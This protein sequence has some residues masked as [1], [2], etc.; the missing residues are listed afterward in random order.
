M[1][2]VVYMKNRLPPRPDDPTVQREVNRYRALIQRQRLLSAL[3]WLDSELC[4]HC[5]RQLWERAAT[6]EPMPEKE[7]AIRHVEDGVI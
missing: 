7:E 2:T 3:G 6:I 1:G 4:Q 5:R